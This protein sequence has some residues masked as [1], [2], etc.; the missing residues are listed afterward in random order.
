MDGKTIEQI[1]SALLS[2]SEAHRPRQRRYVDEASDNNVPQAEIID[3][4]QN[5]EQIGERHLF[6]RAGAS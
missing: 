5:L 4:A 3:I 6:G 1:R 2:R